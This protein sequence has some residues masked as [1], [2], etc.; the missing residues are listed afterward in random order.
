MFHDETECY[1]K[2]LRADLDTQ[3]KVSCWRKV[4]EWRAHSRQHPQFDE[5]EDKQN[6]LFEHEEKVLRKLH[7]GEVLG[8]NS[9]HMHKFL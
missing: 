9:F 7:V 8:I 5:K 3:K 4:L 6:Y 2:Y 1:E